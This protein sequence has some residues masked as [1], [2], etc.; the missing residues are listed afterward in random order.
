MKHY[1]VY[2][3]FIKVDVPNAKKFC[4]EYG[5]NYTRFTQAAKNRR[6]YRGLIV[7]YTKDIGK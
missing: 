5:Y 1:I 3:G 7:R 4:E 6:P 2:D